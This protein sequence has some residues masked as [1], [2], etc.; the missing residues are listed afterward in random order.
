MTLFHDEAYIR[1]TK[2]L[3][4]I[5]ERLWTKFHWVM[6]ESGDLESE[7]DQEWKSNYFMIL[8]SVYII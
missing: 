5:N 2:M 3:M 4:L 8:D 1:K 7:H 6:L